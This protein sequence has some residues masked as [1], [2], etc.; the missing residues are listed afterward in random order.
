MKKLILAVCALVGMWNLG[1]GARQ[2]INSFGDLKKKL[3]KIGNF[4]TVACQD[5]S[6]SNV[7]PSGTSTTGYSTL[8]FSFIM[9]QS[10]ILPTSTDTI[11]YTTESAG[12][13]ATTLIVGALISREMIAVAF[14]S[15][16]NT[17]VTFY[18]YKINEGEEGGETA[19]SI[20][21]YTGNYGD[22]GN[23]VVSVASSSSAEL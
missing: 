2:Q 7:S 6:L 11:Q 1:F 3:Y 13:D 12:F 19:K 20:Y 15:K 9:H 21:T 16:V 22:G 5:L 4:V 8:S 14:S 17:A 10:R 18:I 23:V